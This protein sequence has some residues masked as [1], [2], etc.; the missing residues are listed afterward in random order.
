MHCLLTAA[1]Q[2]SM[3]IR[4]HLNA[5]CLLKKFK[6]LTRDGKSLSASESLLSLHKA[7]GKDQAEQDDTR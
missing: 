3:R 6:M 7:W 5:C 2:R 4:T 1:E